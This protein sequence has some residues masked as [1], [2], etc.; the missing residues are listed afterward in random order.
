M[1]YHGSAGINRFS[2]IEGSL[3]VLA[4]LNITQDMGAQS[5]T[6]VVGLGVTG[7]SVLRHLMSE[8]KN[9]IAVDS[10]EQVVGIDNLANEYAQLKIVLGKFNEK[11]FTQAQQI[12]L[13]PGVA[14]T[15]PSV[16]AAIQAGV[17]VIGDV[18]Y[19][20]RLVTKPVIAI[21]GSNGKSSVT[22]LVAN[23]AKQAG[24][25]TAVGGNLGEPVLQLL[26]QHA[27]LYVLELS[28]F[29]LETL[30]SLKPVAATVLNISE[31]HMDRYESL[32]AYAHAKQKI[33][34]QC[35][36]PIVNRQDTRVLSMLSDNLEAVS[37]GLN[38]PAENQFGLREVNHR[39]YICKGK[40]NLLAVDE[41][42]LQDRHHIA[43]ALASLALGE[44]AGLPMD[45]MLKAIKT[46]GGLPHRTQWVAEKNH[47]QWINDSKGTNVGATLAAIE[48]VQVKNKLV[49]IA[50]G[51]AK[52]A[53]FSPL[54]KTLKKQSQKNAL[55]AVVLIGVDAAKIAALLEPSISQVYAR[56]MSDAVQLAAD[57]AEAGDTV[58][59]SP[60]CAS[61]DMFN[62]FEDRG[63]QFM[64]AVA[65]L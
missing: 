18:E 13:S 15:E 54:H 62:G 61:F 53:D 1:D 29:Q 14:L 33:F 57:I 59:L 41:C 19:F 39:Q 10:R 36:N 44:A 9:I 3:K 40:E 63:D 38:S 47:V 8:E 30:N 21:T 43:N 42:R 48:G 28:S 65:A 23:M 50:G 25:N 7:L 37:F 16:Q 5:Y 22:T 27:D 6:L 24:I 20:A 60:A 56:N 32:D 31:D 46:F 64:Q 35:Q 49:L 17:E 12:I 4:A 34:S 45:V 51:M 11:I 2:F 26:Q 58:L 52:D 55:R